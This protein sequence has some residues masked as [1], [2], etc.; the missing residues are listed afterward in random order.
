MS[1]HH[2]ASMILLFPLWL[3]PH[4]FLAVIYCLIWIWLMFAV[5]VLYFSVP[6][7]IMWMFKGI[8]ASRHL[9]DRVESFNYVTVRMK[10]DH[11]G[12]L[13]LVEANF[14]MVLGSLQNSQTFRRF[15]YYE[16][17]LKICKENVLF[18][19]CKLFKTVVTFSSADCI[20]FLHLFK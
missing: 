3:R 11:D 14:K 17:S 5:I 9:H 2:H 19:G 18:Q 13:W 6:V 8:V 15:Y 1:F 16:I 4:V 7:I 12:I 20:S 10:M